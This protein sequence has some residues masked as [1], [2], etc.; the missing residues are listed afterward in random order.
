MIDVWWVTW[1]WGNVIKGVVRTCWN[2]WVCTPTHILAFSG[3]NELLLL[4]ML[5]LMTCRDK[6]EKKNN[7]PIDLCGSVVIFRLSFLIECINFSSSTG[8]VF[9]ITFGGIT[10]DSK[11][12]AVNFRLYLNTSGWLN[13]NTTWGP[14]SPELNCE[15]K[16]MLWCLCHFGHSSAGVCNLFVPSIV[17]LVKE[18]WKVTK[19]LKLFIC[20]TFL[21]RKKNHQNQLFVNG[22]IKVWVFF[23]YFLLYS[24]FLNLKRFFL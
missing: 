23:T 22:L 24:Y 4:H 19:K 21:Q 12:S 2:V 7:L 20:S 1:S 16:Y 5:S 18:K 10:K 14:F 9:H 17:S 6:C 11:C 13:Q 15:Q 3:V 8:I